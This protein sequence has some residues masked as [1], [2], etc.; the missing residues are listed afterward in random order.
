MADEDAKKKEERTAFI[1]ELM[2]AM[3]K[4][5]D[6]KLKDYKLSQLPQ[7]VQQAARAQYPPDLAPARLEVLF[8]EFILH[9][10]QPSES[11][12]FS[13]ELAFRNQSGESSA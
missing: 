13:V 12:E 10:F 5:S 7:S 2:G 6:Q 1:S 11:G 8:L 4:Q 3:E 9:A